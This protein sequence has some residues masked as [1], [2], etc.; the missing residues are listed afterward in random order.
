MNEEKKTH[1]RQ[2]SDS[3]Q[4]RSEKPESSSL[5]FGKRLGSV[6]KSP[7]QENF[8]SKT[9]TYPKTGKN[10]DTKLNRS[11]PRQH[12]TLES[13]L[14]Q[15]ASYEM[16]H[17]PETTTN[18]VQFAQNRHLG[19]VAVTT[20]P[21]TTQKRKKIKKQHSLSSSDNKKK[22]YLDKYS[23]V[24]DSSDHV[25]LKSVGQYTPMVHP[26]GTEG[27]AKLAFELNMD[28]RVK[29]SKLKGIFGGNKQEGAKKEKTFLGSPK[30]H[31]A[32]FRKNSP[33]RAETNW[34]ASPQV[35]K[36]WIIRFIVTTLICYIFDIWR[37]IDTNITFFFSRLCLCRKAPTHW[38]VLAHQNLFPSASAHMP[39]IQDWNI[40]LFLNR[41][42]THLPIP[43]IA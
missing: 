40:L 43:I 21:T 33:T 41:R 4:K 42:L 20:T 35:N 9:S 1:S 14:T 3:S 6:K 36:H 12:K 25:K 30:L 26:L 17:C 38:T 2:A 10:S 8:E 34:S 32:I 19:D 15:Y 31:R 16:I 23:K 24:G 5:C 18:E 13:P 28:E 39:T 11:L 27:R 29:G 22:Q 7:K 37:K